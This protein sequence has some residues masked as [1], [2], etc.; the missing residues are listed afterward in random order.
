MEICKILDCSHHT[1]RNKLRELNLEPKKP[2]NIWTNEEIQFLKDNYKNT[3]VKEIIK[4][5]NKSKNAII[6]MA[7][8]LGIIKHPK[9]EWTDE[10]LDIL[11][12]YYPIVG[13]KEI[14][15]LLNN[16]K[17]ELEIE[18][19]R[20]YLNLHKTVR[21]NVV[22]ATNDIRNK[23][24]CHVCGELLTKKVNGLVCRK[25]CS[26]IQEIS[27]IKKKYGIVLDFDKYYNTYD[28]IQWYRW[29]CLEKTPNGKR[30]GNLP[31]TL[32]TEDNIKTICYY[33][34]EKVLNFK[35]RED[36]LKLSINLMNK[37]RI[38]FNKVFYVNSAYE[39]L[40]YL[41]PE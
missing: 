41:Y 4:T 6:H 3:S 23:T 22:Y 26:K 29:T 38:M 34:I 18:T 2:D 9:S 17:S 20:K 14:I 25:C 35:N 28:I 10:E 5:I 36:K 19:K 11:K 37:Y 39:L 32:R 7:Y 15:K 1:V 31:N 27:K 8:K 24:H 33:V 30:L 16:T 21:E 13:T 40:N 12:Q